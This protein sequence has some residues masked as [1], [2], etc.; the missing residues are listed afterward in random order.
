MGERHLVR[1]IAHAK[2]ER[3][4]QLYIAARSYVMAGA[5]KNTGEQ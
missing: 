5:K 1:G 3:Y 2:T 4:P